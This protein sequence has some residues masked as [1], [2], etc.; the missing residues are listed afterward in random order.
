MHAIL[1]ALPGPAALIE[2]VEFHYAA[3]Q[4]GVGLAVDLE[5]EAR[6]ADPGNA[7]LPFSRRPF[8][9]AGLGVAAFAEHIADRSGD[10]LADIDPGVHGGV[11]APAAARRPI[12][13][14]A[15]RPVA[16]W[17]F[18]AD[19]AC[20]RSRFRGRPPRRR[21]LH[22]L[23]AEGADFGV[24]EAVGGTHKCGRCAPG[25]PAG[26]YR[27]PGDRYGLFMAAHE[28][29]SARPYNGLIGRLGEG[30]PRR[31]RPRGLMILIG[32]GEML[33][34]PTMPR[35]CCLCEK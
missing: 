32:T 15:R 1:F 26:R 3:R 12:R 21:R 33:G 5:A 30:Y 7:A 22:K 27:V 6:A 29:A 34:H 17:P 8:Q 23:A 10:A 14:A 19:G 9:L 16:G 24:G 28:W 11:I 18:P 13:R 35:G 20:R 25:E 2:R 31:C 4:V